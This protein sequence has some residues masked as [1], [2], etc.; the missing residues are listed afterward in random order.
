MLP[1]SG[2][3]VATS[4]PN[5]KAQ[6]QAPGSPQEGRNWRNAPR[7]KCQSWDSCLPSSDDHSP[8]FRMGKAGYMRG[9]RPDQG[10]FH[11]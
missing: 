3:G 4:L 6:S 11:S 7:R 9:L 2:A 10:S 8:D 5:T 1:G